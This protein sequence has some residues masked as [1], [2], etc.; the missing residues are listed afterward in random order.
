M[1]ESSLIKRLYREKKENI[2]SKKINS[3]EYDKKHNSSSSDDGHPH[4]E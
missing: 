3:E 2:V 4:E 1:F